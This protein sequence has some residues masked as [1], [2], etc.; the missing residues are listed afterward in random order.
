MNEANCE[1]WENEAK[2]FALRDSRSNIE[3]LTLLD[4]RTH[5]IYLMSTRHFTLDHTVEIREM[6][7]LEYFCIDWFSPFWIFI[8]DR[9]I[10]I[11]IDCQRE[12]SWNRSCCH[13]E[14]MRM[15]C[16]PTRKIGLEDG[17][18]IHAK[19]M[20]FIDHHI[21]ELRKL[22]IFLNQ[23]V[24]PKDNIRHPICETIF[25]FFFLLRRECSDE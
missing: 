1:I 10:L 2:L 19:S 16:S 25:C 4:Q 23:C 15:A 21:S 24:C 8:D 6:I 14:H 18:F 5:P 3:C 7:C 9:H 17:T 13:I 22:Y 12:G 11:T 20:L